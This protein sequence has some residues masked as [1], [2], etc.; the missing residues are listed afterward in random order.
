MG[1]HVPGCSA[2]QDSHWPVQGLS[3]QKPSTQYV[4]VHWPFA[5]HGVPFGR[6]PVHT[7]PAQNCPAPQSVSC[8]QPLSQTKPFGSQ[9]FG[10]QLSCWMAEQEPSP[11]QLPGSVA[12]PFW[13]DPVR[14]E[15]VPSGYT[16]RSRAEPSQA[17]WHTDP[18]L[19]HGERVPTGAPTTGE[20]APTSPVTLHAS[21]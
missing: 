7:P 18:S 17:P 9:S 10:S 11:W 1:E 15:I 19:A 21:H 4:L 16:Q 12:R 13:H 8:A 6:V 20:H 5:L 3:Q 14:H 2:A